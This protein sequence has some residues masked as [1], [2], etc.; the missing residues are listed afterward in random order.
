[1]ENFNLEAIENRRIN[2]GISRKSMAQMLNFSNES[3]YWKYEKGKYKFNAETLSRLAE[4]LQCSPQDFF[5]HS[6]A[7]LEQS[8]RK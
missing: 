5:I 2:L 8:T 6:S 3:V 7:I 4:I 1:M